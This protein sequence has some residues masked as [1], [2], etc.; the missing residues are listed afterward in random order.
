MWCQI[1]VY[2][3][4]LQENSIWKENLAVYQNNSHLESL[5]H[6]PLHEGVPGIK[7]QVTSDKAL[8]SPINF[9]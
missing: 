6:P 8:D 3:F 1:T 9:P 2:G 4:V 5:L 7:H